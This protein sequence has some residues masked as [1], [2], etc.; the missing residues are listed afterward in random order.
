MPFSHSQNLGRGQRVEPILQLRDSG[1]YCAAGDFYVDPWAPVE[2][3]V[4]THAH[5]D[6]AR[7]GSNS[8]LCARPG[9]ALL[10]ARIGAEGVIESLPYGTSLTIGS[11]SVSLHPA[12]HI[13]GSAQVRIESAGYSWVVSGDYKI[14]PDRTVQPFEPVRCQGFV[15]EATFALPIFHWQPSSHTFQE[16]NEWWH[17]NREN[18]RASVLYCYALGKAQRLLAGIDASLGPIYTHGSVERLTNIYRDAGVDLPPTIYAM[19]AQVKTFAGALVLAPLAMNGSA[20]VRRFGDF[21]TAMASGWM[22]IRG[23]R[24][25]R[26][27][28]RGFVLSDHADWPGLLTAIRE[29]G[30][31]Q[32]WVTHCYIN[33]LVR[34]LQ[35]K[36]ISAQGLATHFENEDESAKDT[37]SE[38][39]L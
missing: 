34:W 1:L 17:G 24:R 14:E 36:G 30:A 28:D 39:K 9:A 8:Y 10:R 32:V 18:Q 5:R 35:E 3:A 25:R 22:Q 29:T 12:G 33:P 23:H 16:I 37:E 26:A 2:R 31:E 6:H 21:S 19:E 20:W 38:E 13:L 4:I 7:P 15:T 27:I 11:A